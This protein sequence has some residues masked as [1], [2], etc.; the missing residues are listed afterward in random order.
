MGGAAVPVVAGAPGGVPAGTPPCVPVGAP[1]VGRLFP[2]L[3]R[4]ARSVRVWRASSLY[5]REQGRA[6]RRSSEHVDRPPVTVI[7]V[8]EPVACAAPRR[9]ARV[10]MVRTCPAI[11]LYLPEHDRA[12]R[13]STE[14]RACAPLIRTATFELAPAAI[15]PAPAMRT[16]AKA[17]ATRRR[18]MQPSPA[19]QPAV[20]RVRSALANRAS[21][22][23]GPSRRESRRPAAALSNDPY[24]QWE[25]SLHVS[26][27]PVGHVPPAPRLIV[28]EVHRDVWSPT[29]GPSSIGEPGSGRLERR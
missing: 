4:R 18:L 13:R 19:G 6:R 10:R 27:G 1:V 11:S 2:R 22:D 25:V 8:R 29:S 14:H 15:T 9:L 20:W 21:I 12:R 5:R 3:G 17:N 28:G 16:Q 26:S 7:V 24:T 23:I